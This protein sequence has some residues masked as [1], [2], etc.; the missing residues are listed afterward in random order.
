MDL[1]VKIGG[2]TFKNPIWVASG[3]FGY[4]EEYKDFLNLNEVGAIITKTVTLEAREGNLPPRVAETPS[5]LLNSIGLENKGILHFKEEIYPPLKKLKTKVVVSIAG[6]KENEFLKCAEELTGK[7]SPDA[8]ELNLSCPNVKHKEESSWLFSQDARATERIVSAVKKKV[9]CALIVKLTPNVTD[10]VRIAK[11][12]ESGGADAVSL[13]NTYSGM[14]VDAEEMKPLLGNVIGGLSG[15]A[16]K[17]L[18][19][20]AVWEVYKSIKIPVIGIGGIM[21][22]TDVA[23]FMLCGAKAVQIG[24]A[25]C[26]DP[27]A[28]ARILK[29]FKAYLK[30]KKIDKANKLV[31]KLRAA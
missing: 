3:T 23:E 18:A 21:T 20:K 26:V 22:G 8:I 10:I 9:K 19:L 16:I 31:G 5:G 6:L 24:T 13:V 29:E 7:H 25:N 17:P 11:A 30:R 12:A 27:D 4:G 14:A 28:H 15:P 2:V 1:S